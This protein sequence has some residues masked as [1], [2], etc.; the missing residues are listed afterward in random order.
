MTVIQIGP[1]RQAVGIAVALMLT[2]TANVNAN[3]SLFTGTVKLACEAMLCLSSSAG[4]ATAAC[5]PALSYFYGI[6]EKYLSDTLDARLNF[7][8]QCPTASQTPEMASL[9]HAISRGAGRCDATSLN[10]ALGTWHTDRFNREWIRTADK[11]PSY[12]GAYVQHAY[13]DLIETT[14]KYVGTPD[15]RGYWVEAKNYDQELIKY[16]KALEQR[17]REERQYEYRNW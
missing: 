15:E 9:A 14:P 1:R 7:L 2:A 3:E 13:T 5:N 12:C 17:K 16:E 8:Q 10:Y 6:K 11:M 4:G